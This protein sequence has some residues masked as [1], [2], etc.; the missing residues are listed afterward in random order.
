VVEVSGGS[1]GLIVDGVDGIL[2]V[3]VDR[4][5]PLP[6]AA[7]TSLGN[8]IAAVGGRLIV[9]IDPERALG[10]VLARKPARARKPAASRAAVRGA[11]P[12]P[13]RRGGQDSP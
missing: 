12:Q 11:D 3:P 6:P 13:R 9:V 8:E 7:D 10:G 1:L 4:I 2:H 5:A